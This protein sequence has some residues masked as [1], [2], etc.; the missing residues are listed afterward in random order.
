MEY[1]LGA[2]LTK[3]ISG[4]AGIMELQPSQINWGKFN[5]MPMPGAVRMW[6]WHAFAMGE[7]FACTYRF[8]Q[9]LFG[10][11]QFHHGIM[12]TDGVSLS[13][14]GADFVKAVNEINAIEPQL[15][16]AAEND[17]VN[18]SRTGF[19]W[20]PYNIIDIENYRHQ[21]DWNTWQHIH[22]YYQGLKRMGVDVV[23]KD[24]GDSLDPAEIPFLVVPSM[25]MMSRELI[26]K[27]EAYASAD[28]R[29]RT[30]TCG[31]PKSSNPSGT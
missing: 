27:L 11:E 12:Q 4:Y 19:L 25:Q 3:S 26:A 15:D 24:P 5:A 13:F 22:T 21:Q 28:S 1:S 9:P 7:R 16:P 30:V 18:R 14:G 8:R 29:T 6:V 20:S 31:K 17:F 23:F 2:D 10:V